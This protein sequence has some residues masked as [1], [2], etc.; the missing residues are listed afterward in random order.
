MRTLL[1]RTRVVRADD[2][3]DPRALAPQR[4]CRIRV[5]PFG[6]QPLHLLAALVDLDDG[7]ELARGVRRRVVARLLGLLDAS[8]WLL[9]LASCCGHDCDDPLRAVSLVK[10]TSRMSLGPARALTKPS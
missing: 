6:A 7:L 9:L 5:D 4:H 2:L 1:E 3:D 8:P 10:R